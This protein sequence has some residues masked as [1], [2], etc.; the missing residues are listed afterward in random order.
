M[1]DAKMRMSVCSHTSFVPANKASLYVCI[2]MSLHFVHV[3]RIHSNLFKCLHDTRRGNLIKIYICVYF[4]LQVLSNQSQV[5][6]DYI[7]FC[8]QPLIKRGAYGWLYRRAHRFAFPCGGNSDMLWNVCQLLPRV[9]DF[10]GKGNRCLNEPVNTLTRVN[11][12]FQLSKT[13]N[14]RFN[15]PVNTWT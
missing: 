7:C 3:R 13:R 4:C 2:F 6:S 9:F 14:S 12:I 5:L 10:L 8:F 11:S 15:I 1:I